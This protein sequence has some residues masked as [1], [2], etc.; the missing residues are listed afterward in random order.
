MR[1]SYTYYGFKKEELL[2]ALLNISNNMDYISV[3]VSNL[4]KNESN[5]PQDYIN[6]DI[7]AGVGKN[8][9]LISKPK[10]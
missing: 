3:L 4:D 9:I 5:L 8:D 6:Y 7:L 10:T 2:K 1:N